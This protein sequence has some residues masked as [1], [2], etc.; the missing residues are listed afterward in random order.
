MFG[1]DWQRETARALGRDETA[2]A[3]FL[4]GERAAEDSEQLYADM[5]AFMQQ[6]ASDIAAAAE[7]FKRVLQKQK[8]GEPDAPPSDQGI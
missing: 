3:R 6:R 4:L 8:N 2:L 5:V 1:S 7:H